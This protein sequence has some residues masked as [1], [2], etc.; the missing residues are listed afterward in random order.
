[1]EAFMIEPPLTS[2]LTV[3][4][5]LPSVLHYNWGTDGLV[6]WIEDLSPD[7]SLLYQLPDLLERIGFGIE[8]QT[9]WDRRYDTG[10]MHPLYGYRMLLRDATG[11]WHAVQVD[12]RGQFV[13]T[14]PLEELDYEIAYD[15]VMWV[16]L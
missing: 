14:V 11:L 2:T 4:T 9:D 8:L 7:N 15:M 6:L 10:T 5:V 16:D 12:E 3:L 1:M 13:G